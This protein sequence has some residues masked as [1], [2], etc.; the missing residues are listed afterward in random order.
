MLIEIIRRKYDEARKEKD[1]LAKEAY[2]AAIAKILILEKSGKYTLP[3]ADDIVENAIQKQVNEY[4]E[5]QSYYVLNKEEWDRFQ[6]KINVLTQYLPKAMT[7]E[8]VMEIIKEEAINCQ[9]KGKLIGAVIKRIGNRF[10][11]AKIA[12]LVN[13]IMN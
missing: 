12:G 2:N 6:T 10:D 4:K 5:T 11:K 3:L 7:E 13:K 1:E 8:E 9:V